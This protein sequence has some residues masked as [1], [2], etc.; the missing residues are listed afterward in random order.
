MTALITA[1]RPGSSVFG[2]L[3]DPQHGPLVARR[4]PEGFP[5]R[6]YHHITVIP[7]GPLIGAE[8]RGVSLGGDVSPEAIEEIKHAL[9][10][11]KVIHFRGQDI[12][13]DDQRAFAQLLGEIEVHPF[14][15]EAIGGQDAS[16]VNRFA[17]EGTKS[18][19]AYANTW[20]NDITFLERPTRISILR[21][22]VI[23]EYGGDTAFTDTGAAYDTLPDEVKE[24][25]DP[26]T[27]THDWYNNFGRGLSEERREALRPK[28]PAPHHPVVRVIPETGRRVLFVNR[29][30]TQF[31][32]GLPYEESGRLLEYLYRHISR[33]EFQTRVRWD[34]GTVTIWDNA[35]VQHYGVSDYFPQTRIVERITIAGERPLGITD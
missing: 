15:R 11:W 19:A 1:S 30:F 17:S 9:L 28:Y 29:S 18:E 33:P 24:I 23:P 6:E 26:L 22:V 8:I 10:V 25:I 12:D 35:A 32:D 3:P 21:G 27:A 13:R 34:E 31:I 16:D 5:E 20:H 4:T 7:Q 14:F 2:G